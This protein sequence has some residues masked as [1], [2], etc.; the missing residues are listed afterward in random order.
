MIRW[1]NILKKIKGAKVSKPK[2]AIEVLEAS[3]KYQTWEDIEPKQAKAI[4]DYIEKLEHKIAKLENTQLHW[5]PA[6]SLCPITNCYIIIKWHHKDDDESYSQ[7]DILY[8]N[9]DN[10][11]QIDKNCEPYKIV[12]KYIILPPDL[13]N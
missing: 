9:D 10:E 8:V 7:Y 2:N 12:T 6:S 3:Y 11:R 1:L 4:L 5:I 13:F